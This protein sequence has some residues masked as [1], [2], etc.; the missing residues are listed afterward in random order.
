M[1]EHRLNL[2]ICDGDGPDSRPG[3]Y[4]TVVIVSEIGYPPGLGS[5]APSPM[6][7][8]RAVEYNFRVDQW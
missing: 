8:H 2:D 4:S 7:L 1:V 6:Q 5:R 3:K